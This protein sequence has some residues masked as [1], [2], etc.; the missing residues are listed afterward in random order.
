MAYVLVQHNVKDYGEWK[1]GFDNAAGLRQANGEKS[2]WIFQSED[3]PN[4]ITGLFEWDS[5]ENGRKYFEMPELKEAMKQAGVIGAPK[6]FFL[7]KG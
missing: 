2:A 3:D 1:K 6:I 4:A 5:L 7:S